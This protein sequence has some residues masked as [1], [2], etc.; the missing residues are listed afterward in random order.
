MLTAST[1]KTYTVKDLA[2]LAKKHGVSGWHSM[3]KDQL[4]AAIARSAKKANSSKNGK[5]TAPRAKAAST[6]KT[7]SKNGT[8]TTGLVRNGSSR[9]GSS[10]RNGASPR[11]GSA[12]GRKTAKTTSPKSSP[13]NRRIQKVHADREA[14]MDLAGAVAESRKNGRRDAVP[15]EDR[16]V[17][18]VRDPYWLHV[19][20][21]LTPRCVERARAALSERWHGAKPV[22]RLMTIPNKNISNN[23]ECLSR[24]IDIHG[25]VRNWYIDVPNP[26]CT[27]VVEIGYLAMDGH[28][29]MLARSNEVTTP[30]PGSSD[31]VDNHW[32]D[33][34]QN[35]EKIFAMSGGYDENS[36]TT[37][38]QALFEERLRRPMGSPM[39]TRFGNGAEA[40]LNRSRDLEFTVDAE[41]VIFGVTTPDA[42]VTMSGEPIKLRA[43]G[44]F[45]TR[46]S[47]PDCRQV[48]P[49][50]ATSSDGVE[51]RTIILAVE[52]N[53][54]AMEPKMR[55]P[56]D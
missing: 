56:G 27:Y 47:L 32:S 34:I 28:F 22:L 23:P 43:D 17:L 7:L 6:K 51:E 8:S 14:R 45:V 38:L 16:I 35:P 4:V 44:S 52:K 55:R 29:H 37:D 2:Q 10:S 33:V 53:T 30:R 24:V 25:S 3:R 31:M 21:E 15:A 36:A 12:H 13:V 11:N 46:V 18:M 54:K 9:N 40:A 41:M 1:L 48:L 20:W 26:P 42:Y 19:Y 49:I 5:S 39:V 50:V